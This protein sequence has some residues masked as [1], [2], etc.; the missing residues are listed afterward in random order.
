MPFCTRCGQELSQSE[1]IC[2]SCG[3]EIS[4]TP[5]PS[6]KRETVFEGEI[7]KCPHCGEA[8]P[9][10]TSVCPACGFEI[11][12]S[13]A[14]DSVREFALKLEQAQT[15]DQKS[16]IIRNF[17]I[18][19][20]KEDVL[21]FMVLA[22]TN[23]A[24]EPQK[25]MLEAWIAKFEQSYQKAQMLF[26]SDSDFSNI[27]SIYTKTKNQIYNARLLHSTK[28]AGVMVSKAMSAMPNPA[29]GVVVALMCVFELLLLFSG[30]VSAVIGTVGPC[31]IVLFI[32][33]KVTEKQPANHQSRTQSSASPETMATMPTMREFSKIKI[34]KG[35]QST[36]NYAVAE[37]LLVQAGF[38]NIKTVPL[39]DLTVG[40]LK[41][42]GIIDSIT[43]GGKDLNSYFRKSFTADTPIIISYHSFR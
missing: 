23:I 1:K 32:T 37:S 29:F 38:L 43:V 12:G 14:S 3:D 5:P 42:P 15:D 33:Y 28:T 31:L 10:F 30:G 17:P 35:I 24:N 21:E 27:Q 9:S 4:A 8:L 39:Q 34:P 7:H 36:E 18:P 41:K 26:G 22:S 16:T 13:H 11:R 40:V 6:T 2:P 25:V 19:N 20:T